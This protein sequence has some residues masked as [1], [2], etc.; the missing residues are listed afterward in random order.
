M[1]STETDTRRQFG[2]DIKRFQRMAGS[3]TV[4]VMQWDSFIAPQHPKNATM[5]MIAPMT[6]NKIG[7]T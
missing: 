3:L 7:T 4:T 2:E 1:S 6:M 5:K